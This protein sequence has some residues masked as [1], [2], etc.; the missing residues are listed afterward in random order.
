MVVL[1]RMIE[2]FFDF[3]KLSNKPDSE[4]DLVPIVL[5]VQ[6][7]FYYLKLEEIAYV[8]HGAKAGRYGKIYNRVDGS[9]ICD[10][11]REYDK[12][13]RS[14]HFGKAKLLQD[15]E[16]ERRESARLTKEELFERY[17][18]MANK[19]VS[20]NA[21]LRGEKARKSLQ[22]IPGFEDFNKRYWAEKKKQ[23]ESDDDGSASPA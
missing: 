21:M 3:F 15:T 10:F 2:D 22:D 4:A 6:Q 11:L 9:V 7:E 13:E 16:K 23:R 8:L 1:Q 5:L 18:A 20:G 17:K 14:K 19:D 12:H